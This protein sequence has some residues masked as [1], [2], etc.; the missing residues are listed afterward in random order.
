M[1]YWWCHI[2][3]CALSRGCQ[4]STPSPKGGTE[5]HTVETIYVL[6]CLDCFRSDSGDGVRLELTTFHGKVLMTEYI[7]TETDILE[8]V[9]L[10]QFAE[11]KLKLCRGRKGGELR[12]DLG[13]WEK[14]YV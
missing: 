8:S 6:E 2:P 11:K 4:H 13:Y 1:Q 5:T 9:V 10:A 7:A 3:L 14:H 12:S